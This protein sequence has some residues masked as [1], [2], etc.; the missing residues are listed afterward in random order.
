MKVLGCT[1]ERFQKD[2]QEHK[3]KNWTDAGVVR[4]L[5][6]G[7]PDTVC[8]SFMLTTWP[9]H[10]AISGDMGC[11]VFCRLHDMFEFFRSA[12]LEINPYYWSEKLVAIDK[13][14]GYEEFS[15][16]KFKA[17][18]GKW[19]NDWKVGRDNQVVKN[20]WNEIKENILELNNEDEAY[21]AMN[22][23]QT[24]DGSNPFEEFWREGS[25]KDYTFRFIW[26]LYA[27]VW[28]IQQYDKAKQTAINNN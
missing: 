27:I 1:I 5:F 20:V 25:F 13:G 12:T 8:Y 2:T 3:M 28:G 7:K 26:C 23:F 22:E 14:D 17:S 18:V 19:F 9:G 6:F 11:Y 16:E 15:E 10:L 21:R 24:D 4:N